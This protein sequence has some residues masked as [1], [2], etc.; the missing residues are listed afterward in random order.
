MWQRLY[1]GGRAFW[2]PPPVE[3]I[4]YLTDEDGNILTD[5]D[6]NPF[7]DESSTSSSGG[8]FYRLHRALAISWAGTYR[9]ARGVQDAQLPDNPNFTIEDARLWYSWLGL[10][11]SGSVSLA[12]MMAAIRQ[13]MSFPLVPLH[14]QSPAFIQAQLQA[15]GFDVYVYKNKFS[16]G[17]GGWVT[18]TPAEVLGADLGV[19]MHGAFQHGALEHGQIYTPSG[20]ITKI[21]NYLEESKDA[22]FDIGTNY[23]ATFYLSGA[24]ITTFASIPLSR[25]IE[26]RQLVLKYKAA[27]M[28]GFAFINYT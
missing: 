26:F 15:A 1:P 5:E 3:N 27:Q 2:M 17:M 13:Q 22:T 23:K 4:V 14:K 6:G 12:D 25:K 24:S 19:A 16:D 8:I 28:C 20:T 21:V 18:K 10:Y 9:A 11:D 7:I